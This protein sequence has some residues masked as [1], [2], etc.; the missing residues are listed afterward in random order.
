MLGLATLW[1]TIS[2]I[3]F[4]TGNAPMMALIQSQV[5]NQLQG[6]VIALLNTV[7][8]L[9]APLGLGLAAL[10][11]E[12]IGVRGVFVVSGVASAAICLL[13]FAAP[14]L[15]RIEETPIIAPQE[16]PR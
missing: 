7:M 1:W 11:G 3:T 8:G 14:S 6:R 5:P 15:L 16:Q 4:S 9:A 2:G 12:L 13:G 10:L